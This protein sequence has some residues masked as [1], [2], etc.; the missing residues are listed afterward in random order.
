MRMDDL[1]Q[2][3]IKIGS[4]ATALAAILGIIFL[5]FPKFRPTVA[6]SKAVTFSDVRVETVSS[7]P[8]DSFAAVSLKV[9]I[10]G[11]NNT[12]L[13]LSER[14]D[15]SATANAQTSLCAPLLG[16]VRDDWHLVDPTPG[17]R[18]SAESQLFPVEFRVAIPWRARAVTS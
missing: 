15:K 16:A 18:A 1:T 9:Q 4:I 11:Y 3:I 12:I 13:S 17:L 5:L 2:K 10:A 8:C 7:A 6:T 14:L